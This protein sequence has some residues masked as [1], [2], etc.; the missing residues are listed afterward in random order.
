MIYT[1]RSSQSAALPVTKQ[2]CLQQ[3]FKL[4]ETVTLP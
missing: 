2:I 4:S 1:R 3:P